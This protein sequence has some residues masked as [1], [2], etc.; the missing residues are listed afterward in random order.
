MPLVAGIPE[1]CSSRRGSR[2]DHQVLTS[3]PVARHTAAELLEPLTLGP[4]LPCSYWKVVVVAGHSSLGVR[5]TDGLGSYS[6]QAAD[7]STLQNGE[8]HLSIKQ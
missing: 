3:A 2:W 6:L 7:W 5:K 4:V 8:E 1:G